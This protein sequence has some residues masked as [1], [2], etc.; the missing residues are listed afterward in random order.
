MTRRTYWRWLAPAV[1][2]L[3]AC[4]AGVTASPTPLSDADA[5]AR[6]AIAAEQALGATVPAGRT[7]G[8]VPLRTTDPAL[9]PLA[10]ALADLILTDLARSRQIA[11][12]ER[13]RLHSLLRELDLAATGR[14]DSATAP[15][16]G[17]LLGAGQLVVGTVAPAGGAEIR[18][19]SRIANVGSGRVD[20]AVSAA[21]A[22]EDIL[23]AEK[24]LV[25]RLF[26]Q[27]G[28][29]LTP[30]ERALVEQRPTRNLTALLAYGRGV[31]YEVDGR[32]AAATAE[33]ARAAR[34]DPNFA[35]ARARARELRAHADVWPLPAVP[36]GAAAAGFTIGAGTLG[37]A[38][39]DRLNPTFPFATTGGTA[40]P[41]D[42][43]FPALQAT[44]I[45]RV[46]LP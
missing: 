4:R 44:V 25:F 29:T 14:L 27:L 43:V 45:I 26:D 23:A 10:Y 40:T 17:R 42:P 15:R 18:V 34:L 9:D 21:A 5:A 3:A 11:V 19:D 13:A 32:Y 28:V 1:A 20:V 6:A 38:M 8:V 41:A 7:V 22:L 31:R 16:A 33:Y 36:V 35:L 2:L 37:A 39:V 30:A 46:I 24:E 12:V